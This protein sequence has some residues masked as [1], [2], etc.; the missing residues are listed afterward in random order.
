MPSKP[1]PI[2]GFPHMSLAAQDNDILY[3]KL[4]DGL[5]AAGYRI[6]PDRIVPPAGAQT[7]DIK[8]AIGGALQAAK[9]NLN[10]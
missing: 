7:A 4:L 5:K 9:H 3:R 10:T 2:E 1:L 8:A 6:E